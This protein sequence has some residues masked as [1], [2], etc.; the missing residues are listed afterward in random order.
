MVGNAQEPGRDGRH[1]DQPSA[2]LAVLVRM[3]TDEELGAKIEAEDEIEAL[4]GDVFGLVKRFGSGIGYDDVDFAIAGDSG[5]EQSSDVG[6][7]GNVRLHGD[8]LA[9]EAF[10]LADN[11]IGG[12]FTFDV[13]DDNGGFACSKLNGDACSDSSACSCH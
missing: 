2:R 7:L 6:H 10:D 5:V 4:L 9:T 1:E 8:G 3:L 13:V 11:I 12:R